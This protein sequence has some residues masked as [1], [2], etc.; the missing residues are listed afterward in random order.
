VLAFA[1]GC[2][3]ASAC[4]R[5]G[6]AWRR[7]ARQ[8]PHGRNR[9][10]QDA[11]GRPAIHGACTRL[12]CGPGPTYAFSLPVLGQ[13][14]GVWVMADDFADKAEANDEARLLG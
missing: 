8:G 6:P 7:E 13:R 5:D 3:L 2:S 9:R 12:A 1:F 10:D 14:E 11:V 4:G